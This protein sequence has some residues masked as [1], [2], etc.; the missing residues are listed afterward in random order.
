M[1]EAMR[2][3]DVL[4]EAL[5]RAGGARTV[6]SLSG[7]H[8]MPVY[9]ALLGRDI[10][11]VHARH[12]AAAVHMAD[13]W[14]R[15]TGEAG[16]A[17][18]TGGQG[19][20]NAVAALPTAT[21]GEVPLVL[22]SG[23]APLAE[24]GLGAFQELDNAALAAPVAK[25]AWTARSAAGLAEDLARAVRTARGGRPGPVHLSLPT[26]V[27]EAGADPAEVAWPA[28]EAF[29]PEP[30]PLPP[31]MAAAVVAEIGAARRPLVL[32]PPALCTPRGRPLLA[33]LRA[34]LGVPVLAMESPR[35]VNDPSLGA[36]AE[37]LA[38]A[39]LILLLGKALDFTLRFGRPPAV[40][41]DARWVVLEP[42]PVL[43]HRAARGLGER[44][45]LSA[46]CGAAE[47]A[48]ALAEAGRGAAGPQAGWTVAAEAAIAHRP[49]AW[50]AL[51]AAPAAD[52]I[53][54]VALCAAIQPLLARDPDAV[55]VC[56]GGEI[57]QWAQSLLA[58]P[59]R[60]INGVAGAIG[61][62]TPFAIGARAAT[63]PR[64]PIVAVMGDGTF[65]FHM[66]EFD[67]AVR[68]GLP[69]VAVVG[70]DARWN[71]EHQIQLREYG[72]Q[73]AHGCELA[74][75]TRYDLV[76]AA[77]G[78]H[79]EFVEHAADLPAALERAVASGKPACVNVLIAGQPA[80]V[81]RRG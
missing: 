56:D 80:P 34:S 7:N 38:E 49:A 64:A 51:R 48:A 8:I 60:I 62:A 66:A 9:D 54:P 22:L 68:H 77:L 14:G 33:A 1:A 19:H 16:I 3:A 53:H 26:D 15:L 36:F 25:A 45:A 27:I 5:R 21:A 32:A 52:P 71:A 78:G 75:G 37:V 55:L 39:D 31:R 35:G 67:T 59:T 70:N 10:A 6:F 41:R 23:H 76:A 13:A 42:D 65:G 61:A 46:L 24:V 12:E 79:G 44:L 30:M 20:T 63:G 81:V 11:L 47:A 40:A 18:V 43:L 57:G 17:L 50:D 73:R 72:A 69:F 29:A 74:P 28:P 58:A 4:V 2:G